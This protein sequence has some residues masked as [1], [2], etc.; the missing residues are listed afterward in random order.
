MNILTSDQLTVSLQNLLRAIKNQNCSVCTELCEI[1]KVEGADD[2]ESMH[3]CQCTDK[4]MDNYK[5]QAIAQATHTHS[6]V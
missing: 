1:P 3:R 6:R 4:S 5:V 2:F